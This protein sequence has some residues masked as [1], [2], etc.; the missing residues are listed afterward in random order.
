METRPPPSPG[1]R[2]ASGPPRAPSQGTRIQPSHPTQAELGGWSTLAPH[3]QCPRIPLSQ[4]PAPSGSL[5][6]A[7]G[8]LQPRRVARPTRLRTRL[9][10]PRASPPAHMLALPR[11]VLLG[12]AGGWGSGLSQGWGAAL[13]PQVSPELPLLPLL[14]GH[15]RGCHGHRCSA[16]TWKPEGS[17]PPSPHSATSPGPTPGSGHCQGPV[18]GEPQLPPSKGLPGACCG[19]RRAPPPAHPRP[20]PPPQA[21]RSP[22]E[23]PIPSSS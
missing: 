22:K 10:S 3:A 8:R 15:G 2:T 12:V 4:F 21:G 5:R 11:A 23:A 19:R 17:G 14:P 1:P 9:F 7:A 20:F 6:G 13:T 16:H 18:G